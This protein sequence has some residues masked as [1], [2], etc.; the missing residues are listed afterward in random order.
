MGEAVEKMRKGDIVF[1]PGF[2]GEFGKVKIFEEEERKKL[3]DQK[4]LFVFDNQ[5]ETK[6]LKNKAKKSIK[7]NKKIS[8]F[9]GKTNNSIDLNKDQK[10]A[11]EYKD[12]HLLIIAGPGTGKTRTVTHK[13]IHLIKNRNVSNKNILA[14]TF[15]NKA[16]KEMEDRIKHFV[17]NDNIP[18]IT[19]FHSLCFII[20]KEIYKDDVYKIIDDND[21]RHVFYDAIRNVA[22]KGY[23][24]KQDYDFIFELIVSA[25]QNIL[26]YQ[27]N[28]ASIS[29][30]IE[31]N[32]LADIY[33]SYQELLSIQKAYDFED[34]IANVVNLLETDDQIKK[35]YQDKFKHIFI[36]EYQDLN[37]GQYRIIK[38]L[39]S[40]E[41]SICAIGDPN[42]SIYG[43]RGSDISYFKQFKTDFHNAK[44][45]SLTRNYRSTKAILKASNQIIKDTDSKGFWDEQTQKVYSL[46]DGEKRVKKIEASS[47]KV[48]I[49]TIAKIIEK[50]VGGYS[51]F[52][53]DSGV[54][55]GFEQSIKSFSDFAV[56]Y[57]TNAFAK[58]I[59]EIFEKRGIAYQI[60][61]KD[62]IFLKKGIKEILSFLKII[63]GV[64]AY[65]DIEIIS[66][67]I[68]P[69]IGKKT[70]EKFKDW[71]YKN[72][73]SLNKAMINIRRFPILEMEMTKKIQMKFYEFLN[74]INVY[75]TN[76]YKMTIQEKINYIRRTTKIDSLISGDQ[77]IE[78]VFKKI[79]GLAEESNKKEVF[80]EKITLFKDTDVYEK[81][82]EKVSLMTM[83]AAKG[84]EFSTVFIAGCE[85]G[86][87]PFIKQDDEVKK[88]KELD[89]ERR[90]LFVAMTRAKD[91]LYIS[92]SKKRNIYG[93][94][95][96]RF[97]SPFIKNIDKNLKENIEPFGSGK[98][99]KTKQIQ[100]SLFT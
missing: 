94:T 8:I 88:R 23:S 35:K 52:S 72:K 24:I 62:N 43:F 2:D 78:E 4:R 58:G 40:D 48:E 85:D 80:F 11:V 83:H 64:G 74:I 100:R 57:R 97:I 17:A 16:A 26:F 32:L 84:L 33:K 42:Q 36:D 92:W 56:L 54:A 10:E 44:V 22:A 15:T 47:E 86:Y 6:A 68:I 7:I 29:S 5:K 75:K 41:N 1:F 45:V 69:K 14:I 65:I 66:S 37:H 63:E 79:V 89:E 98:K 38:A 59:S 90:L 73:F 96:D 77:K 93:K 49:E 51:Y 46:I 27:H 30:Q 34:L 60:A 19:T 39:V 53:V 25:K 28:F 99:K 9:V 3:L 87:I 82:T 67:I 18:L 21:R 55:N 12:R 91:E 95:C 50:K 31:P 61:S 71:G 76:T 70:I 81:R 13:I 20:L